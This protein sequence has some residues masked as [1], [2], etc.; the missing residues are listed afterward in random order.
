MADSPQT[1]RAAPVEEHAN[2]IVSEK[3]EAQKS[4]DEAKQVAPPHLS[5]ATNVMTSVRKSP[6][7]SAA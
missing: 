2:A 5:P 4:A 3:E 7:S 1:Q 6:L